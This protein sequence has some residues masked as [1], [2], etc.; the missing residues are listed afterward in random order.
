MSSDTVGAETV[1]LGWDDSSSP[2]YQP[3]KIAAKGLFWSGPMIAWCNNR[4]HGRI[5][6]NAGGY[7]YRAS[8][9]NFAR[10]RARLKARL[11]EDG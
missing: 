6:L 10:L 3:V 7:A 11:E 2:T 4:I 5:I 8:E 9:Q 1:I